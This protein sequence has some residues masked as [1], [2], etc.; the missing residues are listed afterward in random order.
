MEHL[1]MDLIDLTAYREEN[2]GIGWLLTIVCI[3]S[4]FLWAVPLP[5]K[6]AGTVGKALVKIFSQWGAPGILQ[7][8][9][10][11]EFVAD[12]IKHICNTFGIEIRH[13]RARHPMT[14][15]QIER[16]NQTVG[17]GF[18]KMM[19]DENERLQYVNWTDHIDKFIFSYNTTRHDAHGKTPREVFFGY[20]LLGIYRH[21]DNDRSDVQE[22]EVESTGAAMLAQD[23]ESH[24]EKVSRIHEAAFARLEK[25]REYMLKHASVHRRTTLLEPGQTVALAPDADMNPATR[26][27]KLQPTFKETGVVINMTNNN[28]TVV[29]RE[30][31]GSQSRWPVKRTRLLKSK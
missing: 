9:N 11:K 22:E 1:Q 14:Q 2:N 27:R 17:R 21:W 24:L 30:S 5:N 15:G 12:I 3:F 19:W 23:V 8:D 26:K 29:V 6:E 4:K 25:S 10:G 20:K 18:T 28:K 7:S 31:D 16:L 13:G